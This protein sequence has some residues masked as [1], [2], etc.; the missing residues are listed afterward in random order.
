MTEASRGTAETNQLGRSLWVIELAGEH[1]ISTA[2]LVDSAFARI[3]AIGTTVVVDFTQTS[4]IDSTVVGELVKRSRG[5][6]TLLLVAPRG[7]AVRGTL[8]LIGMT[9]LLRTFETQ[10]EALQA[11][12]P[13]DAPSSL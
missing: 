7:S 5:G 4:F 2:P 11:I 8:D 1:D 13:E 3:D 9:D 10:D 12:P 6:E